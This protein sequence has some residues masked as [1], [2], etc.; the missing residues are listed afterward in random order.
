N[1]R[2][3]EGTP[4]REEYD[5]L[6]HSYG[7][8]YTKVNHKNISKADLHS[9]FKEGTMHEQRFSMSQVFDFESLKG[10]LLS[11]SYC[12]VPGHPNFTPMMTEL[13]N[14]FNRNNQ[15]G[16]IPFDYETEIYWGEL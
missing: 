5:H 14:L 8:D 4:F 10:R 16:F 2:L 12:P 6:L 13:Q 7:T 9:F 3:T 1:S 15:D 11:S